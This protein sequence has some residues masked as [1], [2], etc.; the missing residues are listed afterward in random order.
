[1][2]HIFYNIITSVLNNWRIPGMMNLLIFPQHMTLHIVSSI[3]IRHYKKYVS[4]IYCYIKYLVWWFV[5]PSH[6]PAVCEQYFYQKSCSE[7]RAYHLFGKHFESSQT[8]ASKFTV[9]TITVSLLYFFPVHPLNFISTSVLYL[10]IIF[11]CRSKV[12]H[13]IILLYQFSVCSANI[14]EKKY[15]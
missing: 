15:V 4:E 6:S 14:K 9:V 3:V 12:I 5:P 13:I 1:M 10:R 11:W 7:F 8:K 2:R